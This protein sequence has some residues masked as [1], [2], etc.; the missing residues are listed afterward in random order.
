MEKLLANWMRCMIVAMAICGLAIC[1]LWI[2][3]GVEHIGAEKQLDLQSIELWVQMAFFWVVA[4]P[5]FWILKVAWDITIEM[6]RERLFTLQNA[7]RIKKIAKVLMIDIIVFLAGN[8]I[9]FILEWHK[10]MALYCLVGLMGFVLVVCFWSLSHYLLRA[11]E[12]QEEN[13]G[14][15]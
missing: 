7:V 2:P 10:H 6:K 3:I 13:E 9:F 5:C 11:A 8:F 14:I 12:L 1:I 4:M 15:I